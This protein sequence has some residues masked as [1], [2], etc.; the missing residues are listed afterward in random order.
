M[1]TSPESLEG[2]LIAQRK[3]L[4]RL[5]AALDLPEVEDFLASRDH[6]ELQSEDPGAEPDPAFA[7]EEGI[8][9]ELRLIA[10]LVT[11]VRGSPAD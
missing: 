11:E 9:A 7:I 2:R 8:A 10:R 4:V 6:V 3:L 1:S 5:I